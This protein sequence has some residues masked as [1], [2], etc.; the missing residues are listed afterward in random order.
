LTLAKCKISKMLNQQMQYQ[1][2]AKLAKCKISEMQNQ[3]MQYQQN[4]KS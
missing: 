2:N 3:Q 4:A 1:Q